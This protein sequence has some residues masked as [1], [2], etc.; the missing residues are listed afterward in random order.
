[1]VS[2]KK[3]LIKNG[4]GSS[5]LPRPS[6][7]HYLRVPFSFPDVSP[8]LGNVYLYSLYLLDSLIPFQWWPSSSI[9][10]LTVC[11]KE[12]KTFSS[13]FSEKDFPIK[14]L[15]PFHFEVLNATHMHT[16]KKEV[17]DANNKLFIVLYYFTLLLEEGVCLQGWGDLLFHVEL[18]VHNGFTKWVMDNPFWRRIQLAWMAF[19][20]TQLK[21]MRQNPSDWNVLRFPNPSE[22]KIGWL[23]Q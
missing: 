17:V 8:N 10:S 2:G 14:R 20:A 22:F 18:F 11:R 5:P 1:M 21:G 23:F 15:F 12:K 19:L 3:C 13:I 7:C 6:M 4:E 9:L 16:H